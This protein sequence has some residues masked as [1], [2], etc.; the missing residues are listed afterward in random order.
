MAVQFL[1]I[2]LKANTDS[3]LKMDPIIALLFQIAIINL[4]SSHGI[5]FLLEILQIL[6]Y[7]ERIEIGQPTNQIKLYIKHTCE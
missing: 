2:N 4:P 6:C 3:W 1:P 5:Q 7:N